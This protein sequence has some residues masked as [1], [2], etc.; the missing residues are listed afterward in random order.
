MDDEVETKLIWTVTKN[1]VFLLKSMCKALQPR[2]IE[3]FPW[4][5]GV[6]ILCVA[7]DFGFF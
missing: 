7:E 6:A 3:S 1:K 2:S 5:L 4:L